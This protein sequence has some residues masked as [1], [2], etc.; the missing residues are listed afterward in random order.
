MSHRDKFKQPCQYFCL[1]FSFF[2]EFTAKDGLILIFLSGSRYR[3]YQALY[4]FSRPSRT[5][6]VA[7]RVSITSGAYRTTKS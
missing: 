2:I 1:I 3:L 7:L 6:C 5:A 4:I